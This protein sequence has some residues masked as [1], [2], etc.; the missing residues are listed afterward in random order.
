MCCYRLGVGVSNWLVCPLAHAP[1]R[2]LARSLTHP[3]LR[4][5]RQDDYWLYNYELFFGWNGCS[6]QEYAL[7]NTPSSYLSYYMCPAGVH[8]ADL[9]IVSVLVCKS[10]LVAGA[11][12][13]GYNQH[14]WSEI[15]NC[16]DAVGCPTE[17]GHPVAYASLGGHALYPENDAPFHVYFHDPK[18]PVWVGD[19]TADGGKT[20]VPT[21]ENVKFLPSL[22]GLP[23]GAEWD[24][25]RFGGN[26]G[27]IFAE[28]LDPPTSIRCFSEDGLSFVECGADKRGV[29]EIIKLGA[30]LTSDSGP[31]REQ[32][33]N[34]PL[35]R[36]ATYQIIGNKL[37]PVLESGVGDALRCP[38]NVA[39]GA[40]DGPTT[41][42]PTMDGPT[43]DGP[44]TGGGGPAIDT[45]PEV[46]AEMEDAAGEV[47]SG[48]EDM[49]TDSVIDDV[50]SPVVALV[51]PQLPNG[52]CLPT[53]I[54]LMLLLVT[55]VT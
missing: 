49:V 20:F 32:F 40:T 17:D 8:E 21:Q 29:V 22:D 46:V 51:P 30:S 16:D 54:L 28:E 14:A 24:W 33:M 15:R 11:K 55:V 45:I 2:S 23:E 7:P 19:R 36:S 25:A 47:T 31:A 39:F 48:G 13:V 42:G 37:P 38:R 50:I 6:S 43:M 12:R 41:N 4:H 18:Y 3:R 9:E 52:A 34:G 53:G 26:W 27:R 35:Q 10:D 44:M 5:Q 1:T